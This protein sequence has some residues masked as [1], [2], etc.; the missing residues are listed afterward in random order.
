[1]AYG[2]FSFKKGELGA[3]AAWYLGYGDQFFPGLGK[4]IYKYSFKIPQNYILPVLL[5]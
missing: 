4:S 3:E 5:V 2:Q 1:M